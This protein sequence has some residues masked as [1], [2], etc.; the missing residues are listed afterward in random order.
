MVKATECAGRIQVFRLK[1][2]R[3]KY[4]NY[5]RDRGVFVVMPAEAGIQRRSLLTDWIALRLRRSA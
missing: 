3:V 5:F 2:F 1:V 4:I